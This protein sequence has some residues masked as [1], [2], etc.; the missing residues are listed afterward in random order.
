MTLITQGLAST[1]ARLRGKYE[2]KKMTQNSEHSRPKPHYILYL[3]GLPTACISS[4][5]ASD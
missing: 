4:P 3:G 5:Q 1:S 2:H